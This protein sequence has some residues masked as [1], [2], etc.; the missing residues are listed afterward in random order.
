MITLVTPRDAHLGYIPVSL[1]AQETPFCFRR[2]DESSVEK[3]RASLSH[4]GQTHPALLEQLAN[5]RFRII[6]GHRRVAAIQRILR[7]GGAWEKI[8]AHVVPSAEPRLVLRWLTHR[9]TGPLA[10]KSTERGAFFAWARSAG[11]DVPLMARECGLTISEIEDSL[12]LAGAPRELATLIDDAGL[13][14]LYAVMLLRRYLAW[15]RSTEGPLALAAVRRLLEESRKSPLTIK[16]WRFLL[17]FYW[18]PR[19]PFM[20][21]SYHAYA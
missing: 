16:S 18:S 1:I 11:T 2:D 12:E 8:L 6:D 9:N 3:I 17:D 19:G 10:L 13:A 15:S 21:E 20:I 4:S 14:P 7:T 5:G